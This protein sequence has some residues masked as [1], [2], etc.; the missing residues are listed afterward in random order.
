MKKI[1]III[2]V[3]GLIGCAQNLPVVD[4]SN[5]LPSKISGEDVGL[6]SDEDIDAG[7]L[8]TDIADLDLEVDLDLSELDSLEQDLDNLI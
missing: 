6:T 1:L 5:Q 2:L 8:E 7:D 4:D 3:F